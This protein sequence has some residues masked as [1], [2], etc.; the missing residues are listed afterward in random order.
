MTPKNI[1][2]VYAFV[3]IAL[4]ILLLYVS[5]TLRMVTSGNRMD[6]NAVKQA[7]AEMEALKVGGME[8]YQKV[9][10]VY[11]SD[12]FKK[13]QASQLDAFMAQLGVTANQPT[14]TN[15]TAQATNTLDATKLAA[16]KKDV[17]VKGNTN[18][19]FTLVEYSDF[20]CPYCQKF[21]GDKTIQDVLAKYPNDV[22]LVFKNFPLSFHPHAQKA[23]EGAVCVGKLAGADKYYQ[24]ID[25]IYNSKDPS[26]ENVKKVATDL[27]INASTLDNCM[28]D[29]ATAAQV[30]AEMNEGQSL[31]GV[32]GTPG[33]VLLDNT[34]GTWKA[35]A[36]A[37]PLSEFDAGIQAMMK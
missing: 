18:A 35:F 7:I 37:L 21:H 31:F 14:T 11:Q 5:A 16:V 22:N 27:G 28:N 26:I 20:E 3:V 4:A 34:K 33:T 19:R 30:T 13:Q 9:L 2:W 23:A 1:F 24:Y 6:I 32:N 17:L 12:A 15:T 29:P 10:S 8:N 36:G 25:K